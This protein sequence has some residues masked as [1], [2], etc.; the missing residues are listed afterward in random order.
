MIKKLLIVSSIVIVTSFAA[1]FYYWQQVTGLP[2]WYQSQN[3]NTGQ[4]DQKQKTNIQ[5]TGTN[6]NATIQLDRDDINQLLQKKIAEHSQSSQ[7]LRS[8]KAIQANLDNNTLEVGGVFNASELSE[9]NLDET[10]KVILEKTLQSFPQL[11]NIDIYV[12]LVGQPK[13]ENGRLVL[14]KDSKL[15]VGK[16]SFTLDEFAKKFGLSTE[17]LQRYLN[18]EIAQLN[19]QELRLEN[20]KMTIE[21]IQ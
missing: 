2:N 5:V 19:I 16:L 18:L 4:L 10:Q 7:L 20:D 8:A 1:G 3:N 17:Q 21:I 12:G 14:D 15:K 13:I 6:N 9:E 11:K